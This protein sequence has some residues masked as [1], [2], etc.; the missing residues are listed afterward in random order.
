M[1]NLLL[2]YLVLSTNWAPLLSQLKWN[3]SLGSVT[4]SLGTEK[5]VWSF[6]TEVVFKF[7]ALWASQS[8]AAEEHVI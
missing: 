4:L 3:K 1:I 8:P 6:F 2:V 7:S 5:H